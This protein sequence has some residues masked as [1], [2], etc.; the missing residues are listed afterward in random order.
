MGLSKVSVIIRYRMGS[1]NFLFEVNLL[2]ILAFLH[3]PVFPLEEY[4]DQIS[5][6][7]KDVLKERGNGFLSM[8]PAAQNP[9]KFPP[10]AELFWKS[11]IIERGYLMR[12]VERTPEG[13]RISFRGLIGAAVPL[14]Y[15]C[16]S[17]LSKP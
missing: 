16:L 2:V 17:Q 3:S 7:V 9:L 14:G 6:G 5:R 4:Q 13:P 10:A 1:H 11:G 15:A 8:L 12:K